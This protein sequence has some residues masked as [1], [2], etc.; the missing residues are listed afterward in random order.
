MGITASIDISAEQRR[1]LLDLL[2]KYLANTQ[3]WAFGSR[4]KWTTRSNSDLDLVVFSSPEQ[5]SHVSALIEALE[6]SNLPFRV[7]L[8]VWDKLPEN[9]QR[10]I[11]EGYVVLVGDDY[12]ERDEV[13]GSDWPTVK[14]A[15]IVDF[16]TG[17]L[18]SNEAE[19]D[20]IYPF[21]T[22]S[23]ITYEINTYAFDTE[24]VLLAGNNA[25]GIFSVK[26]YKGK[27]N[28]YQR[29][30]VI[31]PMNSKQV[32][33]RWLYFRIKQITSELQ[34]LSVGTSTKFLTK[35][36]LDAFQVNL[37]PYDLQEVIADILWS[38]QDKIDN[39]RQTNKTL[40]K[41]ALALFKSWFVDFE[42]VKAKI[43]AKQAGANAEQ[44][45][46][47]ALCA[48]SG[49]TPEQ[50][51]QLNLQILQQLKTTAA[52]FPDA[53]V[54]S[55]L[56]EI[57]EGWEIV[58]FKQIVEKYIDNRG[59]TPPIVDSGIPLLEVK[60]LPDHS[61]KPNVNTDKF[62]NDETYKTWFRAHLNSE[63]LIISTVGTIGRLCMVP[64]GIKIAIAQNLLGLRFDRAFTSPYFMYF[65]MDGK[66]FRDDVNNRLVI[67]VQ[68]SIKRQDLE[69]IDL[70][71]PPITLQNKFES[72]VKPF[73]EMQQSDETF[74]LSQLR[75]SLLPKLLSGELL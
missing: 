16:K 50:L 18:D 49:K 21:F 14:L 30:Y 6:E 41:I 57:P 73:V 11:E 34:Q 2:S 64:K 4:V 48:I 8:L 29:T 1:I 38:L 12:V 39:N 65:L 71:S 26:Y 9:F 43:A 25:S 10:N 74:K 61:I 47:A 37:P 33:V 20:G 54:D 22:C 58:R 44:I 66:R 69:T 53:L 19:I 70:L 15:D 62:V 24:A 28:A 51:A 32:S 59:K 55:E 5:D 68:A 7:D 45:E 35:K 17:K 31:T 56:G 40:E 36:I 13:M 72:F 42:P 27:F 67:T 52:L 60:H 63:D 46:H 23:P 3:V 75:D